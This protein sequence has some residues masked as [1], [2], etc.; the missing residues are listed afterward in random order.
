M[1]YWPS[2]YIWYLVV[3]GALHH[4]HPP[5]PL[6]T[7]PPPRQHLRAPSST[8]SSSLPSTLAAPPPRPSAAPL[9]PPQTASAS[10]AGRLPGAPA[11]Q[12]P[13]PPA[14]SARRGSTCTCN[15]TCPAGSRAGIAMPR[16]SRLHVET[17]G[18][19]GCRCTARRARTRATF[20]SRSS[21]QIAPARPSAPCTAWRSK[22]CT[23]RRARCASLREFGA[24]VHQAGGWQRH[25]SAAAAGAHSDARGVAAPTATRTT[26]GRRRGVKLPK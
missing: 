3:E 9:S 16:H 1:S 17:A 4:L 7:P 26:I 15:T 11:R 14:R 5:P 10:G 13:R 20:S 24:S 19:A 2:E 22:R 18:L 21:S 25:T 23:P 8:R 12:L 6:E